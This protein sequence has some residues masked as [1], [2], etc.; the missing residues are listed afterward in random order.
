MGQQWNCFS[1]SVL[2]AFLPIISH[3]LGL[4]GILQ[5]LQLTRVLEDLGKLTFFFFFSP[6]NLYHLVFLAVV[7]RAAVD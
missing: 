3:A 1:G 7:F 6:Q 4:E 5:D 2:H